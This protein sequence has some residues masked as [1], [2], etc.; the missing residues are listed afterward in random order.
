MSYLEALLRYFPAGTAESEASILDEVFVFSDELRRLISPPDGSPYLLVG[1]KGS[2]KSALLLFTRNILRAQT[3][4]SVLINPSDIDTTNLTDTHSTGDMRRIFRSSIL[5]AISASLIDDQ[6]VLDGESLALEK[7]AVENGKSSGS[8]FSRFMSFLATAAKPIIKVDLAA[9]FPKLLKST[10]EEIQI[11]LSKTIGQVGF[12]VLIDDTDQVANPERPGHLNRIWALILAVRDLCQRIPNLRAVITLRSEVWNRLKHDTAGQRD[13]TD[14]FNSLV[15]PMFTSEEHV[16]RILDRRIMLAAGATQGT[17]FSAYDPFFEGTDAKAPNSYV[18]RLWKDLIVV[19]SR[20]RPRDAIQLVH[21]MAT[22]AIER[23]KNK[24]DEATFQEMMPGFSELVSE[25][26]AKEIERECPQ[27]SEIIREFAFAE[28]TE[29]GFTLSAE[30]TKRH[31]D[32]LLSK[33]GIT[34]FGRSLR[35]GSEEDIFEVWRLFYSIGFLSARASDSTKPNG[36]AYISPSSDPRLVSKA[37]WNDLQKLLWEIHP[38]YRDFLIARQQQR[39]RE[40]GLAYKKPKGRRPN[41]R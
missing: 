23:G 3:V 32:R 38:A 6:V 19:R 9:A 31:F 30:E 20:E 39:Q 36:Y 34:V 26:L 40:T 37:R 28:F 14:H 1:N 18:K 5:A 2:G 29:S 27:A 8:D 4:P 41:R 17:F 15:V 33:F 35:Q 24:I 13:Q 22:L 11:S 25:Q 10:Q 7:F 12:Y 21:K 16:A